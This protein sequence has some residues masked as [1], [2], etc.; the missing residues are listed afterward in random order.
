M[1]ELKQVIEE[2]LDRYFA[3]KKIVVAMAETDEIG[4]IDLA[5]KITGKAKATI[6]SKCSDRTVP[7]WKQGKHLY[8]SKNELT[9]WLR[10]GKRKT[11]TE[12]AADATNFQSNKPKIKV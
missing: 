7:H 2:T 6:Y 9:D 11:Q 3:D 5:V 10:S 12:I 8:F 1:A 4:G